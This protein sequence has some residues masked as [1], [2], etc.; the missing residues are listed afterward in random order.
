MSDSQPEQEEDEPN[1]FGFAGAGT[2]PEPEEEPAEGFGESIA[3]PSSDL[4]G[5][6]NEAIEEA[7]ERR[8]KDSEES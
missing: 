1:R 7:T 4:T 8:G 6:I 5:A 3:V 2:A